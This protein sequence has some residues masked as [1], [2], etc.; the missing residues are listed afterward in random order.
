MKLSIFTLLVLSTGSF[1]VSAAC[2]TETA[3]AA[4]Q[5]DAK[6]SPLLNNTVSTSGVVTAVLYPGSKA[7]GILIQSLTPDNNPKTSEALFIASKELVQTAKPGQ[8]VQVK[9]KVAELNGMTAL[10][11][12]TSSVC[13]QQ[14]APKTETRKDKRGSNS[15]F[16]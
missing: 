14:T 5:G 12:V 3:I 15:C 2:Q 6:Q 16:R 7:A 1:A 11:D 8:Q 13:G 9:G 10:V 4:I